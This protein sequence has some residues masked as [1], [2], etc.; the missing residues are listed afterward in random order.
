MKHANLFKK[1]D[2][3]LQDQLIKIFT[4]WIQ[5]LILGLI[6]KGRDRSL[7]RTQSLVSTRRVG[8]RDIVSVANS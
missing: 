2:I 7:A 1:S 6:L 5:I 3:I 8:F 4:I